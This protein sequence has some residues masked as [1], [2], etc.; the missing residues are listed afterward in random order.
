MISDF[1]LKTGAPML[2]LVTGVV[3]CNVL[4]PPYNSRKALTTPVLIWPAAD[5]MEEMTQI[6]SPNLT[7]SESPRDI[8][9]KLFPSA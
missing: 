2:S 4:S 8:K 6:A 1:L 9:G 3:I 7:L 5:G